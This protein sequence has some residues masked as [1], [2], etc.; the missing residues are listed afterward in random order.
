MAEPRGDEDGHVAHLDPFGLQHGDEYTR[1]DSTERGRMM[2]G[3][4][5]FEFGK[6]DQ[7]N[8][9]RFDQ[10]GFRLGEPIAE[11]VDLWFLAGFLYGC[12]GRGFTRFGSV[13][14]MAEDAV[15]SAFADVERLRRRGLEPPYRAPPVT[16]PLP[17]REQV[18][19]PSVPLSP[20][21][22]TSG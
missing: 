21:F 4:L 13:I 8:G 7:V 17:S 6:P 3:H 14:Q 1:P 9:R 2:A 22:A 19:L 11:D 15:A 5:V 20:F 10:Q 12:D 18:A 16:T